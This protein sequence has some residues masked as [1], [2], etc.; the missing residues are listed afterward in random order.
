MEI[1]NE[2]NVIRQNVAIIKQFAEIPEFAS[3]KK[4]MKL[5]ILKIDSNLSDYDEKVF[6]TVKESE[7]YKLMEGVLPS[8]A[9]EFEALFIMV[10]RDF[11]LGPLEFMLSTMES[12]AAGNINKDKGE[13]AIG[14]H[15]AEKFI[16]A[17]PNLN[18][19]KN[20]KRK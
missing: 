3:S 1:M 6:Q 11:D 14:E 13:M 17:N 8:F 12:I 20:I 2:M 5:S 16:K 9:K 19:S 10:L 7:Y 15:L 18:R 4:Q